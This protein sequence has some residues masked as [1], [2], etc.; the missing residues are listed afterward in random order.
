[1]KKPTRSHFALL[2]ALTVL[3]TTQLVAIPV[4][5]H[6]DDTAGGNFAGIGTFTLDL[7]TPFGTYAATGVSGGGGLLGVWTGVSFVANPGFP[8]LL[9]FYPGAIDFPSGGNILVGSN[10]INEWEHY[11]TSGAASGVVIV[12]ISG[13]V[14]DGGG[15]ASLLGLSIGALAFLRHRRA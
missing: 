6:Y 12:P 15:T 7:S 1:M 14:P 13:G 11:R 8:P 5:Y 3:G 4:T 9:R 10:T 2:A